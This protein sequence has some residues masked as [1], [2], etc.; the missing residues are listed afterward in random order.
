MRISLN[1]LR[2]LLPW[3]ATLVP[4]AALA[5]AIFRVWKV[6]VGGQQ[7]RDAWPVYRDGK[8]RAVAA[9]S[10]V[11]TPEEVALLPT[12]SVSDAGD[13]PVELQKGLIA[14]VPL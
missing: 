14:I 7:V 3:V 9:W 13:F 1:S 10:R 12:L 4:G 2:P 5:A 6:R 8:S 11:L